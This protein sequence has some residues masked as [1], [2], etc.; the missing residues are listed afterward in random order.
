MKDKNTYRNDLGFKVPKGY[1][2]NLEDQLMDH[3][4]LKSEL[5]SDTGFTVPDGYFDSL[6]HELLAVN[7]VAIKE[8]KVKKLNW[9]YP[10]LAVAA[11]HKN[12]GLFL[13]KCA[14]S[15]NS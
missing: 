8:P 12:S 11:K 4:S 2:E 1:F 5:S 10:A 6:T 15:V 7:E 14:N 9:W 3:A 13:I